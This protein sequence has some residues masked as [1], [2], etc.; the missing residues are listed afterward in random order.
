MGNGKQAVAVGVLA[1][2][3]GI[4]LGAN[5]G[6]IVLFLG[7]P[8]EWVGKTLGA[9]YGGTVKF[10]LEQKEAVEDSVAGARVR[11]TVQGE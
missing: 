5:M 10:V 3:A 2:V 1:G 9:A 8:V 7:P 11:A 6:R 4:A